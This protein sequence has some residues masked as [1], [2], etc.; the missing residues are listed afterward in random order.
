M[1]AKTYNKLQEIHMWL[2]YDSERKIAIQHLQG[3]SQQQNR[4][5]KF[6]EENS[7]SEAFKRKYLVWNCISFF[8]LHEWNKSRLLYCLSYKQ[9]TDLHGIPLIGNAEYL[10]NNYVPHLSLHS[11]GKKLRE[12]QLF[13]LVWSSMH[14]VDKSWQCFMY[15]MFLAQDSSKYLHLIVICKLMFLLLKDKIALSLAAKFDL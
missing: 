4:T 12:N 15:S 11:S 14:V 1:K 13:F 2:Y 3:N 9:L 5:K 8:L 7:L 10:T 6:G